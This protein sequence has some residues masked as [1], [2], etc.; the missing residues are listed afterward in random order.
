MSKPS[1]PPKPSASVP[2][3]EGFLSCLVN[4]HANLVELAGGYVTAD[5]RVT[6]EFLVPDS[7]GSVIRALS[8]FALLPEKKREAAFL[9]CIQAFVTQAATFLPKPPIKRKRS[10]R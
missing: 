4:P 6:V 10:K 5:R 2:I 1:Q 7:D 3:V 8:S 9:S